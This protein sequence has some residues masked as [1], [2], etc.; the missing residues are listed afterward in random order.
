VSLVILLAVLAALAVVAPAGAQLG[1]LDTGFGRDGVAL[2]NLLDEGDTDFADDVVALGD[3]RIVA[4][5]TAD[6]DGAAE[7]LGLARYLPSGELDASFGDGGRV[8]TGGQIVTGRALVRHGDGKLVAGG[9]ACDA[10]RCDLAIVRYLPDGALDGS[11]GQG[12][13]A[14]VPFGACGEELPRASVLDLAIEDDGDIVAAGHACDGDPYDDVAVARLRPDGRLDPSFG[15]G[16]KVFIDASPAWTGAAHGVAVDGDGRIV[17]TGEV[18]VDGRSAFVARL[19]PGGALDSSFAGGGLRVLPQ[20]GTS[21]RGFELGVLPD[22]RVVLNGVAVV[23]GF[24]DG[25]FV[26]RLLPDGSDDPSY[27]GDGVALVRG[28]TGDSA[29][30]MALHDGGAVTLAGQR[31][32]EGVACHMGVAR[33]GPAGGLEW[34]TV[35]PAAG[36]SMARAVAEGP[37]GSLAVVGWAGDAEARYVFAVTRLRGSGSPPPP[38]AGPP[39]GPGPG[40][41]AGDPPLRIPVRSSSRVA[42]HRD[43]TFRL[44]LGPF[45]EQVA[46]GRVAILLRGRAVARR[47]FTASRGGSASLRLKVSRR[48]R[49]LA[50][51]RGGLPLVA[52]L[53][54]RD[55]RARYAARRFAFRLVARR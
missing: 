37:G 23:D 12:G 7:G 35:V 15:D 31:C 27:D 40:P 47:A 18:A 5:G 50:A 49:R 30:G 54:A 11:F 19:T 20:V 51:R 4:A 9:G 39:P 13:V 44:A 48:L 1:S 21:A 17:L 24:S 55:V 45:V 16:G 3:G 29:L 42:L 2:T 26:R 41:R 33:L 43:G 28:R 52:R 53:E 25:W 46:D 32:E 38:S 8:V 34:Q 22:R 14:R 6:W 10:E 36:E